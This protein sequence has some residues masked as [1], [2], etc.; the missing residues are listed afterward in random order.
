MPILAILEDNEHG[1]EQMREAP[2]TLELTFYGG[3]M[4]T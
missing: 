4:G 2:I 1:G 3:K